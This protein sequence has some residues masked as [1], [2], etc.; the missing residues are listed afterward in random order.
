M[1]VHT[2]LFC[3]MPLYVMDM[4]QS[5]SV[6]LKLW[7]SLLHASIFSIRTWTHLLS[8]IP[9]ESAYALL[10][11]ASIHLMTSDVTSPFSYCVIA[12]WP[13]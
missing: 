2:L 1:W 10:L 13:E 9:H 5:L 11:I 12:A 4:A 3:T 6:H 8:Q 7:R